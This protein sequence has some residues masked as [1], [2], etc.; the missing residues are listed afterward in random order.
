MKPRK[1]QQ[2][3]PDQIRA[4]REAAGLTQA[5]A[6]ELVHATWHTWWKWEQPAGDMNHRRMP[7]MAWELFTVKVRARKRLEERSLTPADLRAL[8]LTLP[9]PK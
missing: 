1:L 5:Q 4:A 2:P 9:E 6:G 3:T 8:G 7:L